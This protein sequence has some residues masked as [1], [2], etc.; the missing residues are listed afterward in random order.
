VP[1][2][3]LRGLSQRRRLLVLR[4]GR[5]GRFLVTAAVLFACGLVIGWVLGAAWQEKNDRR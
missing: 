3:L 5:L 2:R 1:A 4:P